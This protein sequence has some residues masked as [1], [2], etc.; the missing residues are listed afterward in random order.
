MGG[1]LVHGS[2]WRT[3]R[4][5]RVGMALRLASCRSRNGWGGILPDRPEHGEAAAKAGA[6]SHEASRAAGLEAVGLWW[7]GGPPSLLLGSRHGPSSEVVA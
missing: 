3:G 1:G 5:P 4:Q 6:R 7:G 2:A